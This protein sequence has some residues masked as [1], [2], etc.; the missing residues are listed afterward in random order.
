MK[1][2]HLDKL[3]AY[4]IKEDI[5]SPRFKFD[6]RVLYIFSPIFSYNRVITLILLIL[7]IILMQHINLLIGFLV[8]GA[9]VFSLWYDFE[10]VNSVEIDLDNDRFII[11]KRS[12]FAR[13][14]FFINKNVAFSIAD[15]ERFSYRS[16]QQEAS[17]RRYRFYVT[18]INGDEFLFSDIGLEERAREIVFFLNKAFK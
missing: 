13:L 10:S 6:G 5:S 15:I 1:K 3:I 7:I 8:L 4:I 14:L 16:T 17:S 12:P 11:K 18:L 9:A 2:E